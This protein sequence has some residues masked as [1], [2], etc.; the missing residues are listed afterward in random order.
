MYLAI[1]SSLGKLISLALFY[2][3]N[4]KATMLAHM[5]FSSLASLILKCIPWAYIARYAIASIFGSFDASTM[6]A[7]G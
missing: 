2:L 6:L 7:R 1:C 5:N 3:N 4:A